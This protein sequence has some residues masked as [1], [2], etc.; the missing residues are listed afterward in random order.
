MPSNLEETTKI[1]VALPHCAKVATPQEFDVCCATS[2]RVNSLQWGL[3][4]TALQ[5]IV[6][7]L[8]KSESRLF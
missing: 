1:L 6:P 7:R 3:Y 2:I 8:F 4:R 5:R